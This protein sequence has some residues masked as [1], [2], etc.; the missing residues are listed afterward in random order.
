LVSCL[1]LR[2]LAV[3]HSTADQ[4][5]LSNGGNDQWNYFHNSKGILYKIQ[6]YKK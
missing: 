2:S 6:G 4:S 5:R 3:A 1:G